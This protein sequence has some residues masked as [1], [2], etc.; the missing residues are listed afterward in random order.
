MWWVAVHVPALS[1]E[2]W[3][4]GLAPE[5]ATEPAALLAQHRVLAANAAAAAQGVAPGMRRATALALVPG[6]HL[7]VADARRDAQALQALAH[8]ML[9]FTPSVCLQ[10]PHTV[11]AE[12]QASLRCF[13]GPQRLWQQVRAA[14]TPLGHQ[15]QLAHAPTALAAAWLARVADQSGPAGGRASLP[16]LAELPAQLAPLPLSELVDD[17]RLRQDLQAMGLNTL[18]ALRAQPRAGLSRR[19]GPALLQTLDRAYGDAPDPRAWL[20]P[21]ERFASTLD[22][23]ARSDDGAMLLAAASVLLQRLAAWLRARHARVRHF[24]LRLQH[25]T[26]LRASSLGEAGPQVSELAVALAD[27]SGDP[28]HWQAVLAERLGREALSAPVLSLSLCCDEPV[29]GPPPDLDLFPA[30]ANPREGLMRLVER[31]QAR[32]GPEGVT[33]LACVREHRPERASQAQPAALETG[34]QSGPPAARLTRPVWLLAQPEPLPE[35]QSRPWLGS[36]PLRLLAG[37]ER[38]EAGWWDGGLSARDYFV[39]GLPAGELVW[40]YRLRPA[41]PAGEPGWFL[42][43]RFG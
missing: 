5:T 39:A 9:G 19:L 26:R 14:L 11:L 24:T 37:P 25:E 18:G 23:H 36:E 41:P 22:L 40:I 3:L 42:H 8:G 28:A 43:G 35:R 16:T 20:A 21:P 7:G 1:L 29:L 34:G 38:L 31:L 27:P 15:M 4:A 6:L 13:G 12:L 32:L 10:L 2:S 33:R 17:P 30:L